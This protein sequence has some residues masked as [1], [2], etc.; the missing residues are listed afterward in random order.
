MH[1][2]LLCSSALTL[3]KYASQPCCGTAV[4]QPSSASFIST[5]VLSLE[6]EQPKL[7][8]KARRIL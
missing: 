2:W 1:D 5:F 6:K 3:D 7:T 8:V 4:R